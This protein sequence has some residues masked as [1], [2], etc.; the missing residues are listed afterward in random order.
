MKTLF[1][2][3]LTLFLAG[4]STVSFAD[5]KPDLV[6]IVTVDGKTVWVTADVLKQA[7]EGKFGVVKPKPKLSAA[8]KASQ[9]LEVDKLAYEWAYGRE[10]MNEDSTEARKF[11]DNMKGREN[12]LEAFEAYKKAY[13]FSYANDGINLDRTEAKAMAE[14]ISRLESPSE[15]FEIF[16]KAYVHAYSS[17]GRN[18]DRTEALTFALNAVGLKR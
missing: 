17:K 14:K 7:Y 18:L 13:K 1:I 3:A 2:L 10:G 12:P 16:K 4:Q 11:A 9:L 15:M 6:K 5:D 8:E